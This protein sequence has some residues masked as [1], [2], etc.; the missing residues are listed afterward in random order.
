MSLPGTGTTDGQY[1]SN[2]PPTYT[3]PSSP[4]VAAVIT[5]IIVTAVLASLPYVVWYL[6]NRYVLQD[7]VSLTMY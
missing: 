4:I 3:C 5:S 7:L 1:T 2:V 6:M